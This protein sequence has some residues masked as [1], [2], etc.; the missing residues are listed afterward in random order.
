MLR[1]LC[2]AAAAAALTAGAPLDARAQTDDAW[3]F[4]GTLYL[5]FPTMKGSTTFPPST[6]GSDAN[7][8]AGTI[9]DHLKMTFMGSL[10]ARRQQ[11]GVFTD[12]VYMN[13]GD[14]KTASRSLQIG[15]VEL[16]AGAT[17][18]VDYDLKGWSWTLAGTWRALQRPQ[19]TLDAIGGVRMLDIK[20]QLRWTLSGSVGSV[21]LA[22]RTGDRETKLQ[23]WDAIVGVKGRAGFGSDGRWFAPYYFDI[24]TGESRLT[25]QAMAGVGY[26]FPWGDVVGAWR[27]L[28][29]DMKSG[30]SI[31]DLSFNGPMAGVTFRW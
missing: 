9:L 30:S 19:Y 26:T 20:Q 29:Y 1:T 28:G 23:N 21:A 11:W 31:Q 14:S 6:G 27:Y 5:Y 8:D 16:P 15:G 22:D 10:E 12:V 3:R 24:G 25:W 2:T 4:Q 7:I 18:D 17:A 13:L